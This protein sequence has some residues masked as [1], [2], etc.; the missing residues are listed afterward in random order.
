MPTRRRNRGGIITA[1]VLHDGTNGISVNRRIRVRDQER[2]PTASDVKRAMS[3]K[4]ALGEISFA[5]TAD[6]KEAHI[7][8]PIAPLDWRLLGWQVTPAFDVYIN[9]VGT[10]GIS[11]TSYYW[12]RVASSLGRLAE[13]LVGSSANTWHLLVADDI[14]L[15]AS[16]R[17]IAQRLSASSSCVRPT[18]IM[19]QDCWWGYRSLDR[20][21]TSTGCTA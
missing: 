21:R 16:G 13:Y 6:V 10:F 11:S 20:F 7:Q 17:N 18:I 14:H 5:L 9:K 12:S 3:E 2:F 1:R 4:A 8:V 19:E 15:D